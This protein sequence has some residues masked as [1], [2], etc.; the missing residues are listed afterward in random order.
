MNC[1]GSALRAIAGAAISI[2]DNRGIQRFLFDYFIQ[3][4]ASLLFC[5]RYLL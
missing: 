4:D 5:Q 2:P 1:P 3:L